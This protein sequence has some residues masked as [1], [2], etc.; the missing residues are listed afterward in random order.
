ML[1]IDEN[2][3]DE[4]D[5]KREAGEKD[6]YIYELIRNDDI[7]EFVDYIGCSINVDPNHQRYCFPEH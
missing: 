2:L 5:K 3:F 1:Q 6:R 7:D 4:F